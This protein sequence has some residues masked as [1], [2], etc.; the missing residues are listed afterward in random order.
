[1]GWLGV[2][3]TGGL[4]RIGFTHYNTVEEVDRVLG[5]LADLAGNGSA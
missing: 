3:D 2:A 4:V 5:S 1:M